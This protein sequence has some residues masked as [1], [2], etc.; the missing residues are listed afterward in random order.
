MATWIGTDNPENTWRDPRPT[1]I[2]QFVV[3]N[4]DIVGNGGIDLLQGYR[5]SDY[6]LGGM[7][8][9]LVY[10]DTP[11]TT[12]RSQFDIGDFLFGEVGND[13]I[14]GDYGDDTLNGGPNNDTLF[15]DEGTDVATYAGARA[16]YVVTTHSLVTPV[17]IVDNRAG[18]PEGTD[19]VDLT[20]ENV[21][22]SDGTFTLASLLADDY[23]ANSN[24]TGR[25]SGGTATGTLQMIEDHDWFRIELVAGAPV[26]IDLFGP[27]GNGRL[28]DPYLRVRNSTGAVLAEND[29][30][31]P[32]N[33]AS[34][35][36]FT[37][38]ASG[39]YFI[40]A[41]GFNDERTGLYAVRVTSV[42]PSP[43]V[44]D[45]LWRHTDGRVWVADR[46]LADASTTWQIAGV[47]DFD[48]D[49]DS[50]ILW[51][52]Q[53][54]AVVTWEMERD[55]LVRTHSFPGADV[56]WQIAGTG[57]FDDDSD[58]D[59]LWRNQDGRVLIWELEDNGFIRTHS[60]PSASTTWRI[61]GVGDFDRDGDDDIVWHHSQGQVV[62]WEMENNGLRATRSVAHA[63][64]GWN[65][66]GTG[67]FD[68]DGDDD[69]VWRNAEGRVTTWEM[70][71]NTYVVNHNIES[72]GNSWRIYG[73]HD[74]D[75]DGDSDILWRNDNGTVLTWEMQGFSFL[76][77]HNFGIVSNAWQIRGAGDFDL[78]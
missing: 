14:H 53:G 35:V 69:L 72:G 59:I 48:D 5:G 10:G 18:S 65:I 49:G 32:G 34:Q 36:T 28:T 42:N 27:S 8:D 46:L 13:Q 71:N 38:P 45:V 70:Q 25:V 55:A 20:V 41:A 29:D 47:G 19:T 17:T 60:L 73:V 37:P 39:T 21:R 62:T 9:D 50:D 22:F 44:E 33:L 23:A 30:V 66:Q 58:D 74:F 1:V 75:T 63:S 6:I 40:D 24:T 2:D 15:G 68:R 51:R 78:A 52:N 11:N 31:A 43:G 4:D 76:R 54:G 16:D 56:S 3:E 67:D 7:G 61:A 12:Y 57:D 64:G 26:V 77:T